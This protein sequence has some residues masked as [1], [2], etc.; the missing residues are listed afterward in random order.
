MA[1]GPKEMGDAIVA[2]LKL[3]TGKDLD[4]WLAELHRAKPSTSKEAVATLKE[5][6]LGHFQATTVAAH[7][8]GAVIY[9]SPNR[10]VEELFAKYP[11]QR[12]WFD[13]ICAE[14]VEESQLRV[15]P[16]KRYVP[17][18]SARNVI[19]ASFTPTRDGLYIGL[20]GEAFSFAT[21]PHK[22]SRGGTESMRHGVVVTCVAAGVTAL[23]EA[24]QADA[25]T[26]R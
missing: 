23:R 16:C 6:G 13:A 9:A 7:F 19:V 20:R 15:Q 18:Y 5:A 22:P 21:T 24:A 1:L 17:L 2:N 26:G 25:G 10:L 11:E 4:G 8:F 3:K 14:V 12:Q